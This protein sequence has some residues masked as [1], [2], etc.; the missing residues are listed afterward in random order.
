M[1]LLK[2]CKNWVPPKL[3]AD[4]VMLKT[5]LMCVSAGLA[6]VCLHDSALPGHSLPPVVWIQEQV[7]HPQN[8]ER[9]LTVITHHSLFSFTFSF[10]IKTNFFVNTGLCFLHVCV[11]VRLWLSCKDCVSLCE[12]YHYNTC[13]QMIH[14]WRLLVSDGCKN[15]L[16]V[17]SLGHKARTK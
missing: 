12:E 15:L 1:L 3:H 4:E 6:G 11:R 7:R 9:K 2:S 10:T 16:W 8:Q 13:I 17:I 5:R 14:V